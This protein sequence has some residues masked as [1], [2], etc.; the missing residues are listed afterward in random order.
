MHSLV[1]TFPLILNC[2]TLLVPTSLASSQIISTTSSEFNYLIPQILGDDFTNINDNLKDEKPGSSNPQHHNTRHHHRNNKIPFGNE[3]NKN[4]NTN[5]G[6]SFEDDEDDLQEPADPFLLEQLNESEKMRNKFKNTF[7][8]SW[9][10]RELASVEE[11]EIVLGALHMVHE[12]S[13]D[14]VCGKIMDQGGIQ[15]LEAMLYTLDHINGKFGEMLIPGVRIGVLAKDDCDT[16]IFGLEQ[17]LDFIRGKSVVIC[18]VEVSPIT[19]LSCENLNFRTVSREFV[20]YESLL[21][22]VFGF[23][24]FF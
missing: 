19:G 17:A 5:N 23:F 2:L 16:D 9:P 21:V 22:R 20:I 12:R 10:L 7:N 8:F 6:R 1:S 24:F 3:I 4:T 15:A 13:D 11:G 18:V 14:K